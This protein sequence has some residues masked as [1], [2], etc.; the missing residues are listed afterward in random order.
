V[1]AGILILACW[2]SLVLYWNV[3]SI[4]S[5]KCAAE[6]QNLVARLARMPIWLGFILFAVA[7][8]HPFGMVAI[9]R[10]LFSDSVGVAI[11]VLGLL[12]AIWSRKA[13]GAEWS[14][15]VELKR[16]TN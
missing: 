3:S 11:C 1:P 15:D 10:T 12:V 16:S 13:L 14:R 7:W 4:R 9:Q 2:V 5:I 6:P 8:V